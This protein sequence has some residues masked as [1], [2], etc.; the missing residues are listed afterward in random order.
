MIAPA[1]DPARRFSAK[2]PDHRLHGRVSLEIELGGWPVAA[3]ASDAIAANER[4]HGLRE[5]SLEPGIGWSIRGDRGNR[6]NNSGRYAQYDGDD[7]T[8]HESSFIPLV[9][10]IALNEMGHSRLPTVYHS[11]RRRSLVESF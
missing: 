5:F 1:S 3:M 7:A 10:G 6:E 9:L 8:W 2:L 4:A 11:V